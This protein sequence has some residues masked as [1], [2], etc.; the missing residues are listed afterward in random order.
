MQD[1]EIVQDSRHGG[2]IF[3]GVEISDIW[4]FDVIVLFDRSTREDTERRMLESRSKYPESPYV[5][6]IFLKPSI[7]Y[8]SS[9]IF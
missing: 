5:K 7:F 3:D 1:G 6:K 2:D 9:G 4:D 8:K